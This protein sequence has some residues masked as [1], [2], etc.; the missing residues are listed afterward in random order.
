MNSEIILKFKITVFLISRLNWCCL[1]VA[2]ADV[3]SGRGRRGEDRDRGGGRRGG[4]DRDHHREDR[5][6]RGGGRDRKVGG[7]RGD[8]DRDHDI[9]RDG[10]ATSPTKDVQFKIIKN[11]EREKLEQQRQL[12]QDFPGILKINCIFGYK[13]CFFFQLWLKMRHLQTRTDRKV[14][15]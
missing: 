14:L 13:Y 5:A 11:V 9:E 3:M 2:F 7:R 8:R 4:R 6:G 12:D 15:R 10:F 1:S